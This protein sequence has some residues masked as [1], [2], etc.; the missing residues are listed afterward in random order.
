[1]INVDLIR[2]R[3]AKQYENYEQNAQIQKSI[4]H[5]LIQLMQNHSLPQY[6]QNVLE[7][8]CGT[9][10]LTQQFLRY[11]QVDYL[12]LNDLYDEIKKN[13][14]KSQQHC[15]YLIGDI[16]QLNLK[17]Q[18]FDLVLSSSVLQWIYP[19]HELF[20]KIYQTLNRQGYFIFSSYLTDNFWQIKQITRQGLN[21][22]D[23]D[24][25]KK[26]L[27][28]CGFDLIHIQQNYNDL[29]FY[30]P[31]EV[32][33]H[34]KYTGVTA[35]SVDF[36]WNKQRLIQFN[37]EYQNFSI[38]KNDEILYPLTYHSVIVIAQQVD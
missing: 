32:L 15:Q 26:L 7:I 19:L 30:T 31:Y 37:Q 2:Q 17:K 1:M 34:L 12:H 25:L 4:V 3:F 13:P 18:T 16:Q 20:A 36:F 23:F 8:G 33:K 14:I 35:N 22:Y 5:L 29:Y 24:E 28:H 11:Y 6:Y 10:Y 38:Q 21:Y 9:G 27:L